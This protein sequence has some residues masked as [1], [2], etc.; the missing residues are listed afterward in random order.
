M[1]G[2]TYVLSRFLLFAAIAINLTGFEC[3]LRK[4]RSDDRG[5]GSAEEIVE[6]TCF[7]KLIQIEADTYT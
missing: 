1:E 2:L 3:V 7:E 5:S 4:D 6:Q